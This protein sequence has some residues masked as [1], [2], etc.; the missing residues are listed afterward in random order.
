MIDWHRLEQLTDEIGDDDL[1]EVIAMFLEDMA[2][3]AARLIANPQP[4]RLEADLHFMKGG[5]MA[6]GFDTL[7]RRADAGERLARAGQADAVALPRILDCYHASR[8]AF[9]AGLPQALSPA[10]MPVR[11]VTAPPAP[12]PQHYT[13]L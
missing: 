10:P 3:V 9:L 6:L 4:A 13:S 8:A 1:E 5:A 2:E 7:W 11:A 12:G